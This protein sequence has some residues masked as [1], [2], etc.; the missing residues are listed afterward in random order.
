MLF[1]LAGDLRNGSGPAW[2]AMA[3]ASVA[4]AVAATVVSIFL[5]FLWETAAQL[6]EVVW[7]MYQIDAWWNTV[8]LGNEPGDGVVQSS[9][10]YYPGATRNIKAR[11]PTSHTGE[12][13]TRRSYDEVK[14]VLERNLNVE[15]T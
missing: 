11:I 13:A 10:Q 15:G 6:I 5:P 2:V 1:R 3:D 9:S 12:T 14:D 4:A 7:E 8:A